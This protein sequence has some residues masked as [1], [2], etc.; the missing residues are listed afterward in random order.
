ML[1]NRFEVELANITNLKTDFLDADKVIT[2]DIRVG[3]TTLVNSGSLVSGRT[4]TITDSGTGTNTGRFPGATS[5]DV[6]VVF[7]ATGTGNGTGGG[8]ARDHTPVALIGGTAGTDL[9]GS[10]THLNSVGDLFVGKSDGAHL[11]FDQSA[12]SL[13]VTGAV[14]TFGNDGDGIKIDPTST[15]PFQVG[16]Y[17]AT[18]TETITPANFSIDSTG[19]IDAKNIVIKTPAGETVLDTTTEDPFG[20]AFTKDKLIAAI[21]GLFIFGSSCSPPNPPTP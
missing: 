12:E 4:Y 11:F 3:P 19:L 16:G 9:S 18:A 6:G 8:V 7:T 2:R 17:T 10:G 15:F 21:T 5:N 13:E 1:I 20:S 14:T